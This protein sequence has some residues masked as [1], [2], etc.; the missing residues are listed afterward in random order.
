MGRRRLVEAR[1]ESQVQEPRVTR[2]L[3]W[4]WGVGKGAQNPF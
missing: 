2:R 4:G 1:T 3:G